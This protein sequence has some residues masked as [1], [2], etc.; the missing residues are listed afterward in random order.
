MSLP[1][2]PPLDRAATKYSRGVTVVVAG[3]TRFP[4]AA[5]LAVGGARR[6][7]SGYV[8]F[9]CD[10][11]MVRQLVLTWFPDVVASAALDPELLRSADAF[12]VGC[13]TTAD[14][15]GVQHALHHALRSDAA[16]VVDAGMLDH[17]AHDSAVHAR[18]RER[19]A[20]VVVTPHPGEALRMA[21]A[22]ASMGR[23]GS[24]RSLAGGTDAAASAD[25][26]A[27]TL[28]A[29][30]HRGRPDAEASAESTDD[31]QSSGSLAGGADAA[32]S[33]AATVAS[34]SHASRATHTDYE[35][36]ATEH[37]QRVATAVALSRRFHVVVVLKGAGTIV[38]TADGVHAV[39]AAAGPELATAGTG[40]VLAG[41]LG[42]MLAAHRAQDQVSAAQV[43][44]NA[45]SAHAQAGAHA[46]AQMAPVTALDVMEALPSVLKR[47]AEGRYADGRRS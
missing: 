32:A 45:V 4:G 6:G 36:R 46:S 14:D 16:V 2:F 10:D 35:P 9:V 41:L 21:G 18:I 5:V 20:P 8:H 15:V 43:A 31:S 39:D 19:S 37:A 22:A 17:L 1:I 47:I 38:A 30:G 12:I 11:P 42:G 3:S 24:A 29:R 27:D 13:G 40:D 34:G 44:A 25:D 23:G 33:A 28:S 7:G 26:S